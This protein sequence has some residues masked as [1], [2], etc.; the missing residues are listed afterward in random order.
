MGRKEYTQIGAPADQL[1]PREFIAKIIR[2]RGNSLYDIQVPSVSVEQVRELCGVPKD[3]VLSDSST[4]NTLFNTATAASDSSSVAAA[5]A[6]KEAEDEKDGNEKREGTVLNLV[7]EMPPKFRNTLYAKRGGFVVIT[8]KD[9]IKLSYKS[10]ADLSVSATASSPVSESAT[11]PLDSDQASSP[12]ASDLASD[13]DQ[14]DGQKPKKGKG[15]KNLKGKNP[16]KE[17]LLLAKQK[18]DL[19]K[20][21]ASAETEEQEKAKEAENSNKTFQNTPVAEITNIVMGARTWQKMAYWPEEYNTAS[22]GWDQD[23][24]LSSDEESNEDDGY[25]PPRDLPPSDD[26]NVEYY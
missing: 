11:T 14:K 10:L 5:T 15:K 3:V 25:L 8:I 9:D 17:K 1:Y 20:T 6:G 21:K 2:A 7:A 4:E 13:K 18:K 23:D 26:E 16:L 12:D 22:K 24:K 19:E